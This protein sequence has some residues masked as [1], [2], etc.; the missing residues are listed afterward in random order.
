MF[1]SLILCSHHVDRT[2]LSQGVQDR[3]RTLEN[4]RLPDM[5]ERIEKASTALISKASLLCAPSA[6]CK[7]K[8]LPAMV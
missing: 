5:D 3:F 2:T 1:G 8:H 6:V 4:V 7:K